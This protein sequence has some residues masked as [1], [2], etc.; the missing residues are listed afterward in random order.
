MKEIHL[1][2]GK[3][4][5]LVDDADYPELSKHKWNLG[6]DG[7]ARRTVI[8]RMHRQLVNPPAGM[9][10]DHKNGNPLDNQRENL[11]VA[12]PT[13]NT[14]NRPRPKNKFGATGVHQNLSGKFIARI[15]V[16]G[17]THHL[18]MFGTLAEASSAYETAAKSIYGEFRRAA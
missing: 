17:R 11:R 1:S 16:N 2:N 10:V 13:Q 15:R 7:Y 5:V 4:V 6:S 18:G 14:M 8:I 12:T 3:G 9:L